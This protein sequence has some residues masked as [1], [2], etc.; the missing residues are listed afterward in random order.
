MT[1]AVTLHLLFLATF[2]LLGVGFAQR[3][4]H[5]PKSW[6]YYLGVVAFSVGIVSSLVGLWADRGGANVPNPFLLAL[7]T[8]AFILAMVSVIGRQLSTLRKR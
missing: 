7:M 6:I 4:V 3:W 5:K 8:I 1:H 2:T